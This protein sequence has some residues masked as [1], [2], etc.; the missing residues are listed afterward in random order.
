VEREPTVLE[1]LEWF[2]RSVLG[3]I[4]NDHLSFFQSG[5]S[6]SLT[7]ASNFADRYLAACHYLKNDPGFGFTRSSWLVT[8][9]SFDSEFAKAGLGVVVRDSQ[10]GTNIKLRIANHLEG[11]SNA[12][13][14]LR[15]MAPSRR[16]AIA[17]EIQ[18]INSMPA[19]AWFNPDN[20]S[21]D[22]KLY[23]QR[24]GSMGVRG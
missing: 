5:F 21:E 11:K 2:V 6:M 3:L 14:A 1:Y 7:E 13:D 8:S 12:R 17:M 20:N 4:P 22:V 24:I 10:G 15:N 19:R 9:G 23:R 18:K 16:C